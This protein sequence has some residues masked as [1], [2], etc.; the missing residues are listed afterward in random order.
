MNEQIEFYL[1]IQLSKSTQKLYK[2]ILYKFL[3]YFKGEFPSNGKWVDNYLNF[4]SCSGLCNK[5][6]NLHIVVIIKFYERILKYKDR[7]SFDRLREKNPEIT[8][9]KD[10][11]IKKILVDSPPKFLPVLKFFLDTGVRIAELEWLSNQEFS[12]VP[13]QFVILGKGHKQ[14][15]VA[16]SEETRKL[17]S[18]GFLFGSPLTIRQIQYQFKRLGKRNGLPKIHVHQLRHTFATT[19]L[20]NGVALSDIK[21]MLGHSFL[22]TTAVYT[23]VTEERLREVWK[24]YHSSIHI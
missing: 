17:L 21:E 20:N 23:H 2:Y 22:Q 14:R 7:I 10:D 1:K 12:T 8:F 15:L 19:A 11:E 9:L 18:P 4:L 3:N 24:K 16:I 5:S 13:H 6:I